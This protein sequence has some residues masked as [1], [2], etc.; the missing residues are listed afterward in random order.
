VSSMYHLDFF[1]WVIIQNVVLN[2]SHGEG[3]PEYLL[4]SYLFCCL[5]H[6]SRMLGILSMELCN[7]S[8]TLSIMNYE[9]IVYCVV[10]V[11]SHFHR[12]YLLLVFNVWFWVPYSVL[13]LSHPVPSILWA[14]GSVS[15]IISLAWIEHQSEQNADPNMIYF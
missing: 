6:L 10:Y 8:V 12:S 11:M 3:M 15:Q 4:F 2:W 7:F 9:Y 13:L 14:V 5:V 1:T